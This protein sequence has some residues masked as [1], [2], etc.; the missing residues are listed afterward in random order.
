MCGEWR[1]VSDSEILSETSIREGVHDFYQALT[2]KN[3]DRLRI[4]LSE[5]ASLS[6][7][8]YDFVGKESILSWAGELFELFPFMTFKEKS[9]EVKGSSVKHEFLI[10]FMTSQG[11]K[12]WLPC[13]STYE[14]N[15]DK[16]SQ[17]KVNLLHGFLAVDRDDV[18]RVKP[19]ATG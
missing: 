9:L 16:I 19:H 14:F 18:E 5:K 11:Q 3:L 12:G 10:A 1:S 6:W 8:P 7:G 17:V 13:E 15:G 2:G 4:L